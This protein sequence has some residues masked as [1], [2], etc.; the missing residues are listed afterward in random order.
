VTLRS[1]ILKLKNN[2]DETQTSTKVT[3]NEEK[4]SRLLKKKNEENRKSYAEVL[5]GMNHGQPK[6]KKIVED[7]S[8]RRPSVCKPQ[9][10]FNHDH[11]QSKK[12]FKRT[13]TKRISVTPRYANFFYGH[14]FYCTNFGHKVAN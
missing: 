1:K 5:K 4:H 7:T 8:S 14:C 12:K 9:R 11:D 10:S 13:T 2:V 6:S 3:K